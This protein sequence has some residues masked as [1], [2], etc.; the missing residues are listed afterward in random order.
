MFS[1][2]RIQDGMLAWFPA[3]PPSPPFLTYFGDGQFLGDLDIPE[4]ADPAPQWRPLSRPPQLHPP[5]QIPKTVRCLIWK[6]V[7]NLGAELL[8]V[9]KRIN[10]IR[11]YCAHDGVVFLWSLKGLCVLRAPSDPRLMRT[12]I[13]KQYMLGWSP[14]ICL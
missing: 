14:Y 11:K 8:L 7:G 1:H 3:P 13:R 4:L 2:L 9:R 10:A 6:F 5:C 12:H